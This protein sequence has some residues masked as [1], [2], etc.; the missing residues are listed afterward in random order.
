MADIENHVHQM[1]IQL[2]EMEEKL[3]EQ[4][5]KS[6][7]TRMFKCAIHETNEELEESKT[8]V[9]EEGALFNDIR[10]YA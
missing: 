1:E 3:K 8:K 9:N 10:F 7:K 5:K 6:S 2:K 4:K